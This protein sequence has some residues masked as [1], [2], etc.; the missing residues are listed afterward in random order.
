MNEYT[1]H[2]TCLSFSKR[3]FLD[4]SASTLTCRIWSKR[5]AILDDFKYLPSEVGCGVWHLPFVLVRK[6]LQTVQRHS[7]VTQSSALRRSEHARWNSS[8]GLEGRLLG[9][10]KPEQKYSAYWNQ[11]QA[12]SVQ[13]GVMP[14]WQSMWSVSPKDAALFIAY[15]R[16]N[17]QSSMDFLHA[18]LNC[19]GHALE[20]KV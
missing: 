16:A 13:E 15:T 7:V 20:W 5:C 9:I 10:R 18:F 12:H 1:N 4:L 6:P 14:T 19:Y 3:S 2:P 11:F 8:S 17:M